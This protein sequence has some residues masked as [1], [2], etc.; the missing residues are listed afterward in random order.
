MSQLD[1]LLEQNTAPSWRLVAYAIMGLLG[2]F[3]LWSAFA[4]LDEVAIAQGEVVPQGRVKTI[5]HLEGGIIDELFVRDGDTVREGTPLVQ[6]DLAGTVTNIEELQVRRD[7]FLIRKARLVAEAN[8]TPLTLPSN[9]VAGMDNII[10]AERQAYDAR[11]RELNS[12]RAVLEGQALQRS[13]DV[14]EVEARLN[15][16][17]TNL[18]LARQRLTMSADLLKDKLQ[19]PMDHLQIE[20]EVESFEGEIAALTEALPRAQAALDE[21]LER[22]NELNLRFAREAREQLGETEMGIARTRELLATAD[23]QQTRTTIKS[24]IVGVV[25]NMRYTTIGGV[26]R[27]GEP[28]LDIVPSEDTLVVEARLNP[29]DRG[30]VQ[31]GQEATIKIDTYDFVRY[32]G[33]DGE[34]IS[35]APDTTVPE[36]AAPYFKVVIKTAQ[37]WLGDEEDG[38]LIS[39]GMGAT[40]DIHTGTK[41]VMDYL[42]K[43]VLKLKHEAFRER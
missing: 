25:K 2:M 16:V 1:D 12:T 17:R 21:A 27:P 26:V 35:V 9:L 37:P 8:G 29:M 4:D 33:I 39:P 32:G 31:E 38:F 6:M 19:S 42:V 10:E 41:S 18:G 23:D 30:F 22:V 15:A 28:I 40:V 13:Q 34:V 5:Q 11:V 43:P 36:N 14:R 20:S 3:L 24:P 7:G